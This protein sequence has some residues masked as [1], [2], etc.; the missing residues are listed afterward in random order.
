MRAAS[1]R[2]VSGSPSRSAKV[3]LPEGLV[4]VMMDPMLI[5]QV[6]INILQNAQVHAHSTRPLELAVEEREREVVFAVKDYGIGIEEERLGSIFDGDGTYSQES[7]A[8]GNKGIGLSICKTIVMAHGG[9]I[10]AK[11]HG[12]GTTFVFSLPKETEEQ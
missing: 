8:D 2:A 6:L 5:E 3:T 10:E 12:Q 1:V 7:A 9:C 11:N 4:M